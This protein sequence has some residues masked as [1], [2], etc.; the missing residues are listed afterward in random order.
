MPSGRSIEMLQFLCTV[1]AAHFDSIDFV[2]GLR[3]IRRWQRLAEIEKRGRSM[4]ML[5]T[6]SDDRV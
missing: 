2:T 3:P 6:P 1:A 5:D 4:D